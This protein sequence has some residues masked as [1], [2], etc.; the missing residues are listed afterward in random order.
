MRYT[1]LALA[2]F[3]VTRLT[4]ASKVEDAAAEETD[5]LDEL[6]RKE[7]IRKRRDSLEII[8]EKLS[9]KKSSDTSSVPSTVPRTPVSTEEESDCL[10]CLSGLYKAEEEQEKKKNDE[11]E[12]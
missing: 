9:R 10:S 3:F 1:G 12:N 4:A 6:I 11:Q 5:S 7:V 2:S 8:R